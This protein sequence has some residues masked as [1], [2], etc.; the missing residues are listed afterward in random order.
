MSAKSSHIFFGISGAPADVQK[1]LQQMNFMSDQGLDT[2]NIMLK[3]V[4]PKTNAFSNFLLIC[5]LV[6]WL[7]TAL[8]Y[9]MITL[10]VQIGCRFCLL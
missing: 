8:T 6:T 9:P 2:G 1:Y 3:D 7:L 10:C 5:I 4:H